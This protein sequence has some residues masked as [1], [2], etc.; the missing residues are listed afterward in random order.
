MTGSA[1]TWSVE[2]V[3]AWTSTTSGGSGSGPGAWHYAV[4]TNAT[5]NSRAGVATIA[6]VAFTLNQLAVPLRAIAAGGR[7]RVALADDTAERWMSIEAEAGRSYCVQVAQAQAETA[8]ATAGLAA[9]HSDAVAQMNVGPAQGAAM[10]AACFIAPAAETALIRLTQTDVTVREYLLSAEETT[11]W[12]NWFFTGSD[13]SSFTLLRNTAS[14]AVTVHITWR[15]T[16]GLVAGRETV[17]VPPRAVWYRD[18]RL[19][20]SP[21]I[22]AGTVEIAHDADPSALA[23]TQTTLSATTGLSFDTVLRT[24]RPW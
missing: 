5:G 12:A 3:P 10:P 4:G 6:G 17:V 9:F 16:T 20:V 18:A 8:R 21:A 1:C 24:R 13:Y 19:A 7:A 23:G 15:D 14:Y 2:G 11:L 22:T